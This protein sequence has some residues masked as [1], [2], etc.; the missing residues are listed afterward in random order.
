MDSKQYKVKT[1]VGFKILILVKYVSTISDFGHFVED[2]TKLKI[3]DEIKQ[4]QP[5]PWIK[6]PLRPEQLETYSRASNL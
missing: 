6:P 5:P 1:R 4:G 2:G 3:P